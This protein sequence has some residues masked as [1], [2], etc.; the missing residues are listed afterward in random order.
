MKGIDNIVNA[1]TNDAK[2]DVVATKLQTKKQIEQIQKKSKEEID[3]Q[4]LAMEDEN[5]KKCEEL[6]RREKTILD[7]EIRRN[8]LMV[9]RQMVNESFDDAYESLCKLE[10]AEYL[11][12]VLSMIMMASESG[13]EE[14]LAGKDSVIDQK[15]VDTANQKLRAAKCVG[16]LTLSK[17]KGNFVG[18]FV[19]CNKGIETNC[20]FAMLINQIKP[21]I[22]SE[23]SNI[24]F[25]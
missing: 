17:S 9:K 23:V 7:V 21:Q 22:E 16:E 13:K 12:I 5:K 10:K 11:K 6:K 15:L 14:I 2:K 19:L 1:I 24:L 3:K 25:K 8:N 20:T 4:I 18:G